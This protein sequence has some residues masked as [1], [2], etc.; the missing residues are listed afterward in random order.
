[1]E[2]IATR[3]PGAGVNLLAVIAAALAALLWP[4]DAFA[5]G[6]GIHVAQGSF[7][8]ESLEIIHPAIAS[9]LQ[10]HPLDYIYGCISADIFL[11]K[12]YRRRPDHCHNWS[13]GMRVLER[14]HSGPTR[15]Y[16]YGYLTHLAAD[17]VAHNYFIPRFLVGTPASSQLGHVY[18]EFRAD[19]FIRRKF[20][21]LASTV[22]SRHNHD[23]DTHI[24]TVMN[25]SRLRFGTKKM[26]FKRAVH[27][28]DLISWRERVE[29]V[30]AP[31]RR[32]SRAEVSLLNNYSLNLIL[33]FL[34]NPEKAVCLNFDPVGTDNTIRALRIRREGRGL[35]RRPVYNGEFE[36]PGE[37][38][39][40][41][42][43][44]MVTDRL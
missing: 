7:V 42:I 9:V 6:A 21:T 33:D 22:V 8:L 35:F 26:L 10:A 31:A 14:S 41:D 30:R 27:L 16:A 3:R 1:M 29:H 5:W 11:G 17:V 44:D 13:V 36:P 23:N 28:T 12:G 2:R 15:A 38:R 25:R 39:A 32:L 43:V 19:R 24:K 40:M 34:R 18:W 4:G 20:W 37:I